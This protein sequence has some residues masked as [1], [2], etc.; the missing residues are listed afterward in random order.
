MKPSKINHSNKKDVKSRH[1]NALTEIT[2]EN[3][4]K[5]MGLGKPIENVSDFVKSI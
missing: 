2:I 4:L 5:G 1:P 3:A